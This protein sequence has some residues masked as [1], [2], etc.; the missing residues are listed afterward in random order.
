MPRAKTLPPLSSMFRTTIHVD[1]D[2]TRGVDRLIQDRMDSGLPRLAKQ[3]VAGRLTE[4][5]WLIAKKENLQLRLAPP[6]K[7]PR[8]QQLQLSVSL[9]FWSEIN[10]EHG[11]TK[12]NVGDLAGLYLSLSLAWDDT[13]AYPL[14]LGTSAESSYEDEIEETSMALAREGRLMPRIAGLRSGRS[15][16][17]ISPD[18]P[19]SKPAGPRGRT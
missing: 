3:L 9:T 15:R 2:T 17:P 18:V 14:H 8:A 11:L 16:A 19:R 5:G 1:A 12:I 4:R 7:T 6:P 10:R 13:R